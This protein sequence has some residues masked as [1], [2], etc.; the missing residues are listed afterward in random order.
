MAAYIGLSVF[1]F[2]GIDAAGSS[3]TLIRFFLPFVTLTL[4]LLAICWKTGEQPSWRWGGKNVSARTVTLKILAVIGLA[5]AIGGATSFII[6]HNRPQQTVSLFYYNPARDTDAAG[7]IL[8]S[9]QG[10]VA[11]QRRIPVTQTPIQ[12]TVRLLLRGELTAAEKALG[13][14]TEYPLPGVTLRSASLS[15]GILALTFNDPQNATGGGSCRVSILWAQIEA[16]A[17]QFAGV[18]DVRFMPEELFQP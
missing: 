13:I 6:A 1:I 9:S 18:R 14:T 2:R 11:V 15:S 5:A 8:C 16:T 10:L 7:N 17:K 3:D 4:V 12:D